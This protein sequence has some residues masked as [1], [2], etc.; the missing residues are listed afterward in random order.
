MKKIVYILVLIFTLS[1]CPAYSKSKAGLS[2][3]EKLLVRSVLLAGGVAVTEVW[4]A[5]YTKYKEKHASHN[6]SDF[7][8]KFPELR[9]DVENGLRKNM[10]NTKS[11]KVYIKLQKVA[12]LIR[13]SDVPPFEPEDMSKYKLPGMNIHPESNI[14]KLETPE[15]VSEYP[16]ILISPEGESVDTSLEFPIERPKDWDEYIL[17]KQASKELAENMANDKVNKKG[18]KPA[19]YAAHHIVP[20]SEDRGFA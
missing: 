1:S 14:N 20:F 19:G 10:K 4:M 11:E 16:N 3:A 9:E 2:F 8:D 12:D 5:K 17:L 7:L 13:M 18:V 15:Y 6:I